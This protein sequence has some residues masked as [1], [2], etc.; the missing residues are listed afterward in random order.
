MITSLGK[1]LRDLGDQTSDNWY[2]ILVVTCVLLVAGALG[3]LIFIRSL[4][5][6]RAKLRNAR[7]GIRL[8]DLGFSEP[9]LHNAIAIPAPGGAIGGPNG[10]HLLNTPT[11]Q[12]IRISTKK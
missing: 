1:T 5:Q 8:N 12:P 2:F 6:S 11:T 4:Q 7:S 10:G 9:N 3:I